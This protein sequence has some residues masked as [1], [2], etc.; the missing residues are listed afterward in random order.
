MIETK[1]ET[2]APSGEQRKIEEKACFGWRLK[3]SQEI[4]SKESH[5]EQDGLYGIKSVTTKENYVKLVFERDKD[6]P[7]Y[8]KIVELENKYYNN[9][10]S[11]PALSKLVLIAAPVAG[12]IM[13]YL[14]SAL[15]EAIPFEPLT[16]ILTLLGEL[17]FLGSLAVDVIYFIRTKK[18]QK[19]WS[20]MLQSENPKIIAMAKSLLR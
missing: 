13:T 7:N 20:A 8:N 1:V 18:S 14:L 16:F 2:I 9:L 10:Y 15:G 4:N 6:M 11:K 19:A 12:I 3:S 5:L 17:L